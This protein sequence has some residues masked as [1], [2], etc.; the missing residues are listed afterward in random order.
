MNTI[1]LGHTGLRV[2]RLG[3]GTGT[4]GWAGHSEQT[5]LGIEEL[6]SLLREAYGLGVTFWDAA[7]QYGSHPHVAE[8]LKQVPR[9]R[10]ILTTKTTAK[11]PIT[12][13]PYFP[14]N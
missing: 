1:E 4:H 5:A 6:A 9:D 8:A 2:S 14:N 11:K 13:S 3:I 7:D 10:V 12:C